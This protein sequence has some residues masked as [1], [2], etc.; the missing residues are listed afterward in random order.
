MVHKL[1]YLKCAATAPKL[2][3]YLYL[4]Y[5][6]HV[7]PPLIVYS[8]FIF[9]LPNLATHTTAGE[10][11]TMT[12]SHLAYHRG[13]GVPWPWVGGGPGTW[14]IYHK[15]WIWGYGFRY[16]LCFIHIYI[17]YMYHIYIHMYHIYIYMYH[18]YIYTCIIYIY[19]CII[20][21]YIHV[22]YINIYVYVSYIYINMYMYH[23]YIHMYHI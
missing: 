11:G 22:S 14:K 16:K 21:I 3:I 20:Y 1:C 19:T 7:H 13:R 8:Y 6:F 23:I 2:Q 18:I 4:W 12:P 5:F 15:S 10:G 9:N 17:S